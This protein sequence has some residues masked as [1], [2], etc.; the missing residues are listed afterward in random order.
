MKR[1]SW[2]F[3]LRAKNRP[4]G[5]ICKGPERLLDIRLNHTCQRSLK[6]FPFLTQ[7]EE[8]KEGKR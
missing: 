3:F 8:V 5:L 7:E 6:E 4:V 2:T 1:V